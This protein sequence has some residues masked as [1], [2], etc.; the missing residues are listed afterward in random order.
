[1]KK[2]ELEIL[3]GLLNNF[4]TTDELREDENVEF[5]GYEEVLE[6]AYENLLGVADRVVKLYREIY[7]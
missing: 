7:K 2:K 1:M 5:L 6:M 4:M 3:I